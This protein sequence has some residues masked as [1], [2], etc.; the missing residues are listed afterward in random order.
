MFI[1]QKVLGLY[2]VEH[3]DDPCYV[4]L[5]VNPKEYYEYFKSENSNKKHK[6]ELKKVHQVW[7]MKIMQRELNL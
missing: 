4:T 6:K 2:E 7:T 3:I 1:V 5:P